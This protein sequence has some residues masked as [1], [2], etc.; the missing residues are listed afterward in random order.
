MDFKI[1]L[2]NDELKFYDVKTHIPIMC[3]DLSFSFTYKT[4]DITKGIRELDTTPYISRKGLFNI[5]KKD[6]SNSNNYTLLGEDEKTK[7]HVEQKADFITFNLTTDSEDYSEFGLNLPLNFMGKLNS[8]GYKNQYLFNSPYRSEDNSIKFCYLS[9]PNG[10]N[11]VIL[12]LGKADG[13]KMD[14]SKYLGGHYFE[15]LKLL[16]DFDQ[17]YG[18]KSDN[19]TLSFI[20]FLADSY[21]DCL[22]KVSKFLEVPFLSYEKSYSFD[23]KGKLNVYGQCDYVEMVTKDLTKSLAVKDGIVEFDGASEKTLFIPYYKGK[24][25]GECSIY[26]YDNLKLLWER[27]ND[28][29]ASYRGKVLPDDNACEGQC[30]VESLLRFLFRFGD[31]EKYSKRVEEHLSNT[32]MQTDLSLARKRATVFNKPYKQFP[33]YHIFNSYRI[34]E[35]FFAV[36]I[37]L[38]AY[39]VFKDKKYLEYCINSLDT[40][41]DNYQLENGMIVGMQKEDYSTVCCLIIPIIDVALFVKDIDEKKYFKFIN[42]ATMLAD[43]IYKRGFDFPTEGEKVEDGKK[44]FEDEFEDGSISCS[45]LSLLYYS[46][47]V[48]KKDIYIKRAK[49]ILDFHES[50]IMNVKDA[51]VFRSSLRWW[52]TRWE[53]DADGPAICCGHGWTI[54]R[55]EADYWYYKLTGDESYLTKSL[56]SYTTNFAKF[57]IDTGEGKSIYHVDYVTGGGLILD[58]SSVNFRIAPRLPDSPDVRLAY[59]VFNRADETIFNELLY[60]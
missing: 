50:W 6:F 24:K 19:K 18:T 22:I 29:V 36:S 11:L 49:E 38:S 41:I 43:Y 46:A 7:L 47:K 54:W 37:F 40:L 20:M 60:K 51:N 26:A 1:S 4:D 33:A 57:N 42:S 34:Q 5:V 2:I 32:L 58:K 59:Y 39:K 25:G 56:C 28:F 55:A 3:D 35:Q 16:A 21:E 53:G 8:G 52:E 15:N 45:A 14:Y 44:E 30:W 48:E 9:N 10:R 31:M 27:A 12:F 23:G 13:W 17:A